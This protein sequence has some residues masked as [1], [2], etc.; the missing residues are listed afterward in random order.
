MDPVVQE[1][2]PHRDLVLPFKL[3]CRRLTCPSEHLASPQKSYSR[4]TAAVGRS[5]SLKLTVEA[6]SPDMDTD[7][8]EV[9]GLAETLADDTLVAM[10]AV[11]AG[12]MMV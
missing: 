1:T 10:T 11:E 8:G 2:K 4:D 12:D 3:C 7:G 5:S 9:L 6:F